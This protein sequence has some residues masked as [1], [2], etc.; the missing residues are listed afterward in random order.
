MPDTVK[1]RFTKTYQ[2]KD[3]EQQVYQEGKNHSRR[4][5]LHSTSSAAVWR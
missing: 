2:V 1:V 5:L 3:D 4:R